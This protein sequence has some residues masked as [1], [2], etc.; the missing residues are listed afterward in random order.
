M[1]KMYKYL[2]ALLLTAFAAGGCYEDKGSY[3]TGMWSQIEAIEGVSLPG[4]EN[5]Y[6]LD[7]VEEQPLTIDPVVRFKPGADASDF[8]FHW[9]MGGDTIASGLKLDW[10][11]ERTNKMVFNS[12]QETDFWLAIDNVSSGESWCYYLQ[13]STGTILKVKIVQ[14]ITPKIGVFVYEQPDGTV[15]W[16]SVK[17][18]NPATPE[19]FTSLYTGIFE[20]YNAPKT[21]EGSVCGVT[22]TSSDLIIYTDRSP[23]CGAVI[24]TSETG[25]YPLGYLQGTVGD[26]IFDGEPEAAINGQSFYPGFMQELL[27]GTS[28]F[29]YS[30]QSSYQMILHG[31]EP[32]ESGVAQIMGATPYMNLMHFSVLRRTSGEICYYRYNENQGYLCQPL[33]EEDGSTLS[34]DRIVGVCRQ[35]SSSEKAL[36]LFVAV[37]KG[38]SCQLYTYT[39]EQSSGVK[40][41]ITFV[42]KRD[43]S[44]W[45]GGMTGDCRMF[46]NSVEMPLNYLYIAK[47]ADLWRTSYESQADPQI[48]RSFAAP[49]TAVEVV[50]SSPQQPS[51]ATELYTALFTYDQTAGTS[52]MYVLDATS[53][54]AEILSEVETEIPGKVVAYRAN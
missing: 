43:I 34:A 11:V 28:L 14:A 47:G 3:F 4:T 50:S 19:A 20:R 44:A 37:M 22:Y 12:N 18:S 8:S 24:Q 13:N 46:T 10:V 21:I 6:T 45:A 38:T 41:V 5:L 9:V 7:L 33:P 1:M 39:Y 27:V 51:G 42:S 53:D 48:I 35:P 40:D 54:D 32:T 2:T 26:L 49:I 25:S 15:E 36:K 17:G 23:A 31:A 29:I 52:K 16:G 30:A